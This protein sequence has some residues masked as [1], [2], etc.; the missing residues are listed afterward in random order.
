[1]AEVALRGQDLSRRFG[2]RDVLRQVSLSLSVAES[3][4]LL[5]PSGCGKTPL[6]Q[7]LGLLDRPDAGAVHIAGTDAWTLGTAARARLRATS[8]GFVF[9]KNNLLDHLDPR[10]N[11][12][13]A[14]WHAGMR[15]KQARAAATELLQRFG[16]GERL[17]A[18][19]SVLSPGEA[20]RVAIARALIN[21]P[22]VIL[23]DEP[24][25]SLDS[26]SAAVVLSALADVC[27]SGSA[28]LVVTHDRD[29]AARWDRRVTMK[30]GALVE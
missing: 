11:V 4:A 2:G 17:S 28:L 20:Q 7:I 19:T 10:D 14:G 13:L 29:V 18:R 9:Q 27:A 3:V 22:T 24:T 21:R 1:M 25:G 12:A 30:D 26:A 5:G 6:L 15:R 23:A 16:L 8:I